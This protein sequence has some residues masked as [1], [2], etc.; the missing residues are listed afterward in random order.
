M[1]TE[2]DGQ[3]I[4]PATVTDTFA[5]LITRAGLPP[6]RLHDLRHSAATIALAAS[7][8]MKTVSAVLRHSSLHITAD[9]YTSVLPE[10]AT[11]TAENIAKAIPVPGRS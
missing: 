9:T 7:A 5:D 4:H 3:P 6:V 10:L 2:P 1:F 11:T 8:D